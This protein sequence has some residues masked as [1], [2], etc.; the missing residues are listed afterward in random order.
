MPEPIRPDAAA[1]ATLRE[2]SGALLGLDV[3][4]KNGDRIG[5][6]RKST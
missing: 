5:V 3:I 4:E 2:L 1:E 6:V